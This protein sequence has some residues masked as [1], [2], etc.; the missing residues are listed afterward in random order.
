MV[1]PL[2]V[3]RS[4]RLLG[5]HLTVA[6]KLQQITAAQV[7]ERAGI[8]VT[9]LRNLERGEGTSSLETFLRV[10]RVLGMLDRLEAALDP[11]TTDVGRLRMDEQL[12]ERVRQRKV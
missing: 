4:A 1:T 12:P 6:R 11:Y 7:A 8:S 5:E 3:Q 9:T 2:R 10:A